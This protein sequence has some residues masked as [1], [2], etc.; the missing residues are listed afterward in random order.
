LF[1]TGCRSTQPREVRVYLL[2]APAATEEIVAIREQ[3]GAKDL[4]DNRI[5]R[6]AVER[7]LITIG[8]ALHKAVGL[9]ESL[10]DRIPHLHAIVGLRNRL[11]HGYFAIDWSRVVAT[12]E[13]E[14]DALAEVLR[15][16]AH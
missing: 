8:E 2:D 6:A 1:A 16:L 14:I 7:H 5:V 12:V 9:D 13:G 15:A 4:R 10:E 3:V 11:V